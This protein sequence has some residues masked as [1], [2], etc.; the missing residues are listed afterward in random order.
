MPKV[1]LVALMLLLW[2]CRRRDEN[3]I[4][5]DGSSTVYPIT[6]A[7]AEEFL[8]THPT[9]SVAIG[10]SGSGSG[11]A[12]LLVNE[13]DIADASRPIT[14]DELAMGKK[15]G[16]EL[17]ELP[18]A[19]D[20]LS[21]VV[22]PSN[23]WV[24]KLTV[25]ELKKIWQPAAQ[26]K[27]MRWN[28]IRPSFPNS[29]I[30]LYGAG[31]TSGTYDYFTEAIVGTR[32]SSRGDYTS[33]EDYNVL[34]QGVSTDPL[35]LGYVGLAYYLENKA[36]LKAIPIDDDQDSTGKGAIMPT[37]Q[38]VRSGIYQPLTRPLFVYMSREQAQRPIVRQFMSFFLANAPTLVKE[39]GYVPFSAAI[40]QRVRQRF[41]KGQTGSLFAK[42]SAGVRIDQL[43]K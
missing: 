34:V 6:E 20:G 26:G 42:K 21:V 14:A 8:K 38:N 16:L 11:L 15:T 33:S 28:Q 19:Y 25:A 23:N 37:Y 7:V 36:K 22:H 17:I 27:L 18:I 39:T 29:E 12:K 31:I 35:A 30:H 10:V 5:I 40:Y 43:L 41:M 9:L 24:D 1:Q 32:R 2:G 3:L 13:T 4:L